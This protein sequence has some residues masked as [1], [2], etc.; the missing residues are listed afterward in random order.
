M[1]ILDIH[2]NEIEHHPD[3][4]HSENVLNLEIGAGR[5]YFGKKYFPKCFLIEKPNSSCTGYPHFVEVGRNYESYDCHYIDHFTDLNGLSNQKERFENIICCNPY[6][7]GFN[8]IAFATEFFRLMNQILIPGGSF[9]I[10]TASSNG[11]G[12][13]RNANRF[14]EKLREDLRITF[15]IS[16]KIVVDETHHFRLENVFRQSDLLKEAKPNEFYTFTKS[17]E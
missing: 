12:S 13:Y 14:Y 8:G 16:E 1:P 10:L 5:N 15:D 11:W 17:L 2:E 3:F 9:H 4:P 7:Y 6:S